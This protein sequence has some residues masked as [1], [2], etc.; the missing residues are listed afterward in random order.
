[1]RSK[2][3]LNAPVNKHNSVSISPEIIEKAIT[4]VK[5]RYYPGSF[6]KA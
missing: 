2:H 4:A 1:M 6:L 3:A 5:K